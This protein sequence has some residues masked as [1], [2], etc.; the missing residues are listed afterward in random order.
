MCTKRPALPDPDD[1][2]ILDLAVAARCA[3]IV[4]HNLKD[5]RGVEKFGIQAI[6]PH[7]FLNLIGEL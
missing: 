6:K 3:Y 4:T 2:F 5:F 1:D 7:T